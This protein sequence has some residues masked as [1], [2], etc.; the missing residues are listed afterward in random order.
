VCMEHGAQRKFGSKVEEALGT[1]ANVI[2]WKFT[3]RYGGDNPFCIMT[4]QWDERLRNS[5]S[6]P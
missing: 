4:I 2:V 5:D 6:I 1:G 3:K